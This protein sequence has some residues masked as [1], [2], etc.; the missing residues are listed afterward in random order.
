[1]L[2]ECFE[3][4]LSSRRE[5]SSRP[6][7]H[8]QPVGGNGLQAEQALAILSSCARREQPLAGA[9]MGCIACPDTVRTLRKRGLGA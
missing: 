3:Y 8:C 5:F 9:E 2:G 6:D 4:L 1:M 7:Y